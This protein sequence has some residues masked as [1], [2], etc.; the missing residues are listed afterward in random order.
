MAGVLIVDQI[1]NSAN[2]LLIN[3]GALAANTVGTSQIQTGAVSNTQINTATASN[4]YFNG[5]VGVGNPNPG[6]KLDINGNVLIAANSNLYFN[7][8][9]GYNPRI[10]NSVSNDALSVFT[11]NTEAVRIDSSG[12]MTKPLQPSF[13]AKNSTSGNITLTDSATIVVPYDSI[14]F[15]IGSGY[16]SST[17]RFTAPVTGTYY[18]WA[19][20][21]FDSNVSSNNYTYFFLRWHVNGNDIALE[22]MMPRPAG[23]SYASWQ[24]STV[25]QLNAGDY[26]DIRA[27]QAGGSMLNV[28]SNMR[29]FCGFLMG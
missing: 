23:G 21:H 28:R 11:N 22:H 4:W 13:S 15:N 8:A 9:S 29:Q 12:R 27:R 24:N 26:I 10:S 18:F 1:Q 16:N 3:S 25:I 5:N 7:N 19:S 14:D 17:N 20:I 6:Q 2:T